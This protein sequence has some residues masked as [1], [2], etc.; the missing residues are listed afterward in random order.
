MCKSK[1]PS[2]D[3][4][5]GNWHPWA[6]SPPAPPAS[7]LP[8]QTKS[9]RDGGCGWGTSWQPGI[10]GSPHQLE[11]NLL[12][13]VLLSLGYPRLSSLSL[14]GPNGLCKWGGVGVVGRRGGVEG[15]EVGRARLWRPIPIP[16]CPP[17]SGFSD[18]PERAGGSSKCPGVAPTQRP[19]LCIFP[20]AVSPAQADASQVRV[21]PGA[22]PPGPAR[23]PRSS[24]PPTARP[25]LG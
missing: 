4:S 3:L 20:V 8:R 7:L 23:S 2:V 17:R 10:A 16:H 1:P 14:S 6:V 18:R 9:V 13:P 24:P 5:L 21:Q 19:G 15:A 25:L 12:W 22:A 11:K